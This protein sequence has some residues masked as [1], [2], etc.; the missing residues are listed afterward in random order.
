MGKFTKEKENIFKP[1]QCKIV[2]SAATKKN[3]T[4]KNIYLGL[5]AVGYLVR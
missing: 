5:E 1:F 4:K 3:K 2:Q